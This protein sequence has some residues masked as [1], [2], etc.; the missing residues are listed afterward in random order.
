MLI[1][2]VPTL[3]IVDSGKVREIIVM[4]LLKLDEVVSNLD[5]VRD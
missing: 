1:N 5:A 4:I 2:G 3:L